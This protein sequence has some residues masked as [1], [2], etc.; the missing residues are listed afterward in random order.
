MTTRLNLGRVKN[1]FK[2][3]DIS[4][5]AAADRIGVDRSTVSQWLS[6]KQRPTMEHL[7]A[8]AEILNVEPEEITL[9]HPSAVSQVN[10]PSVTN[11][12]VHYVDSINLILPEGDVF[13]VLKK[14]GITLN[15]NSDGEST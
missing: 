14:M 5:S 10:Q 9:D 2:Q 13:E 3:K 12:T 1:L 8:L 4:Y 11:V 15:N 7:S 6:G